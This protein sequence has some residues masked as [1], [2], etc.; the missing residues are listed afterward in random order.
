MKNP[1]V[2]FDDVDSET[3]INLIPGNRQGKYLEINKYYKFNQRQQI[4]NQTFPFHAL[5]AAPEEFAALSAQFP[6]LYS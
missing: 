3:F 4:H 5:C 6:T 2:S 1:G